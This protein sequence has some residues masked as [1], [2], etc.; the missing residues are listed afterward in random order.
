MIPRVIIL[1]KK[2]VAHPKRIHDETK[3]MVLT[4]TST[5][6]SKNYKENNK[7]TQN[8]RK[9]KKHPDKRAQPPQQQ[10]PHTI[11]R[12]QPKPFLVNPAPEITRKL[13]YYLTTLFRNRVRTPCIRQQSIQI[14][15]HLCNLIR[16]MQVQRRFRR[17][18]PTPPTTDHA[19]HLAFSLDNKIIYS[20]TCKQCYFDKKGS[21]NHQAA[22]V[23]MNVL[24]EIEQKQ[25]EIII[26]FFTF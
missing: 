20:S 9:H 3:V 2:R 4:M 24:C 19:Q 8:Q 15:P 14:T 16:A 6:T 17:R 26:L 13:V 18:Q 22:N 12:Q 11:P 5:P 25:R 21:F 1:P 23:N 7:Y 10:R